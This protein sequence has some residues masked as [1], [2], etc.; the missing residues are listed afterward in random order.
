MTSALVQEGLTLEEARRRLW[1]VDVHGLVVKSRSD[2]MPHNR[3]YAHEARPMGFEEAIEAI[4][5]HVLVG[6]TGAPGTFTRG[7]I[8][9]MSRI[10]ARPA[11]FALSNP[12]SNAECTAE[13]AYAWSDGRAIFASG[14]PFAPVSLAGR[15]FRPAQG[16]NAYVFPGIGLG[17]VACRARSLPD[18]LFLTAASTLAGLVRQQDLDEG[19]L[20]PPLRDIR[21]I[22]LAIAT[23]V[24]TLAWDMTLTRAKRPRD[25]RRSIERIMYRA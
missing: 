8:E 13:Q 22:S 9:R 15:T 1:F 6:A 11:I 17:A 4:R 12:T 25:V 21:A 16:N 19:A 20:Y 5:P 2:L 7:V 24:A 23:S 3:P 14:S 18:E 10:N